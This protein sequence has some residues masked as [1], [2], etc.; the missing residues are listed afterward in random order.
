MKK[1]VFLP[2][3]ILFAYVSLVYADNVI[4]DVDNDG[5]VDVKEA[6]HALKV[7]ANIPSLLEIDEKSDVSF[8]GNVAIGTP[9]FYN[10]LTVFNNGTK[11]VTLGVTGI[12]PKVTKSG[13]NYYKQLE[14]DKPKYYIPKGVKD[15]GYRIGLA[16]LG[17]PH[18]DDFEGTLNQ[19]I[20]AWIRTGAY[21]DV[22]TGTIFNSY[23][24]LLDNLIAPN[25]KILNS[26]GLYQ[27]QPE[28]KNYF[29]G[30]VGIGEKNPLGKLDIFLGNIMEYTENGYEENQRDIYF[31][32]QRGGGSNPEHYQDMGG[33]IRL[34]F[35]H[36]AREQ[37]KN[38]NRHQYAFV[39]SNS[40]GANS[41]SISLQF[42]TPNNYAKPDVRMTIKGNGNVG[43][44]EENP[45]EKLEVEGNIKIR[46]NLISDT[47]SIIT[48]SDSGDI[49]IGKCE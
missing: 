31:H 42:G 5:K 47:G 34:V 38:N 29:A 40:E 35:D 7:S 28:S 24:I 18:T 22:P 26:Y 39:K 43:I 3:L 27:S 20:G 16:V 10:K 12:Y 14:I 41:K 15:N 25:V 4:G 11:N 23:G 37:D 32:A 44:G 19:Q 36:R 21:S 6:I 49:C 8:S 33:G 46:G 17:Y 2:V 45:S 9:F 13:T 48:L 1:I 30:S